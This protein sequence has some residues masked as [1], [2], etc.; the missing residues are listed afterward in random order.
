MSEL[1]ASVRELR[2]PRSIRE[3]CQRVLEAGLRGELSHFAVDLTRLQDAAKI[4]A[5]LSRERYPDLKVP[6]HSRFGHFDA[7]GVPRLAGLMAQIADREPR[8]Q[9]RILV[10]V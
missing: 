3:R 5:D 1:P 9:A 2:D 10:D 7:G 4:T 8:E 6:P